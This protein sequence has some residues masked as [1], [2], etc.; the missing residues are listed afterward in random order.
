MFPAGAQRGIDSSGC[1]RRA[2]KRS[3]FI[4]TSAIFQS[5]GSVFLSRVVH[6]SNMAGSL[7]WTE[8]ACVSNNP[9]WQVPAVTPCIQRSREPLAR[10]YD[11][12]RKA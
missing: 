3:S 5:C 11:H 10:V 8:E 12:C 4:A 9:C 7:T 2:C 1:L 6:I